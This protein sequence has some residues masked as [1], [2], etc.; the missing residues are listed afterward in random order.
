MLA[1]LDASGTSTYAKGSSKQGTLQ[2]IQIVSDKK[3]LNNTLHRPIPRINGNNLRPIPLIAPSKALHI[4]KEGSQ[5][6]RWRDEE[7]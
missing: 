2:V 6:G 4:G 5:L 3:Y 1:V 7:L